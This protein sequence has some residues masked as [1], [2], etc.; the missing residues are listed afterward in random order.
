M[1]YVS[2]DLETSGLN[3]ETHQVL[4]IGAIIED[5]EKKLPYSEIPKFHAAIT[6][7]E[8]DIVGSL[9]ALNMNKQLLENILKFQQ[10][11]TIEEQK[12][13]EELTE[14]KYFPEK[15][16]V[17][18]FV[19]FLTENGIIYEGKETVIYLTCAGK[20]FGTF[21]KPYC[22]KL[23]NWKR[24][25]KIRQRILDPTHYY[26]DWKNDENPP[27]LSVC[28]KRANLE[29]NVSH[30]AREDAWDVIMLLRSQY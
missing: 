10:C 26:M 5:T 21:D 15:D 24:F 7:G 17:R 18:E 16:V 12:L 28:K 25:L 9:F 19:S 29:E 14:L 4:S 22:E 1:L 8:S 6:R 23:P 20:N 27:S 11:K 30:V 2:I 13:H 3:H